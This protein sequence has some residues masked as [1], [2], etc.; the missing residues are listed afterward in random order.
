MRFTV[1]INLPIVPEVQDKILFEECLKIYNAIRSL[2][3]GLDEYTDSGM[4]IVDLAVTSSILQARL[5][6]LRTEL[7]E[8]QEQLILQKEREILELRQN[9]S[10]ITEEVENSTHEVNW[11]QPGALGDVTPDSVTAT[12]LLVNQTAEVIGES[13]LRAKVTTDANVQIGTALTVGTTLAVT[14]ATTLSAGAAITGNSSVVGTFT[15]SG[16]AT[17]L[18]STRVGEFGANGNGAGPAWPVPAAAT[19]PATTMALSNSLRDCLRSNGLA[20]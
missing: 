5:D 10:V 16:G 12:T 13:R 17:Q 19:D 6:G 7:I 8:V 4:I 3:Y 1:D 9:L 11:G 20:I 2:A 14:G 15:V 18:S